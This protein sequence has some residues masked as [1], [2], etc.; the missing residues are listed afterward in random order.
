MSL[1]SPD[2]TTVDLWT[3]PPALGLVVDLTSQHYILFVPVLTIVNRPH[4]V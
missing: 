1:M 3:L 4:G 2:L